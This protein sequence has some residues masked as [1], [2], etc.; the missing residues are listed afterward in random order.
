MTPRPSA[1][2]VAVTVASI[3][4]VITT[5]AGCVS[6]PTSGKVEQ[7]R[8]PGSVSTE[9]NEVVPTPPPRDAK[10]KEIV[11]GFLLAMTHYESNY[12]T[13]RQFLTSDADDSWRPEDH[14]AT[15]Y[16]NPRFKVSSKNVKLTLNKSGK[17]GEKSNYTA[18]GGRTTHNFELRR[19]RSGQWRISNPPKGLLLSD[20]SFENS[21]NRY[22]VY[23]FDQQFETLVPEPVHLPTG[24]QT[25]TALVK[26][27]LDGPTNWLHPA[28][29]SSAP[30]KTSLMTNSV[31]VEN[32]LAKISLNKTALDLSARQRKR[33]AVQLAWTLKQVENSDIDG[34]QITVDGDR[35]HVP[36]EQTRKGRTYVSTDIGDDYD[37]VQKPRDMVAGTRHGRLVTMKEPGDSH[38]QPKPMDGPLGRR[39]VRVDS[40]GLSADGK[41]VAAVTNEDSRLRTH[42]G[43]TGKTRTVLT[44]KSHLLRPV[45]TRHDELWAVS[46]KPEGQKIS[47]IKKKHTATVEASWLSK[48]NI[49][50]FGIS[51]DGTR[52]AVILQ[53]HGKQRLAMAPIIRGDHI[54]L[55]K[56]KT[57]RVID[58]ASAPIDRITGLGWISPTRLMIVGASGKRGANEPYDVD[59]DGADV[60]RIGVSNK[61]DATSVS[62]VP[63]ASESFRAIV[64]GRHDKAWVHRSGDRWR[65]LGMH[66]AAPVYAG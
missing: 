2:R 18:Q 55:G 60:Q 23:F 40:V 20:T 3:V 43:E 31:P 36:G 50:A 41:T 24:A 7:A 19:T 46:G 15:I 13:A 54:S 51:S 38:S 6:V 45:F 53:R 30:A 59:I 16:D 21:Y 56:L 64:G 66:L 11:D 37:P 44:G 48:V 25:T 52:I 65:S 62:A 29:S 35:F 34:M 33:L 57:V 47:V 22:N 42:S 9:R 4:A 39:N 63:Y 14:G 28:V 26:R 58:N 17:L 12:R 27:V 32:H 5:L 61:W 8:H 49:T 1:V 10:P